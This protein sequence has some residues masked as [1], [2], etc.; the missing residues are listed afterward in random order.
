[1]VIGCNIL[2]AI[3]VSTVNAASQSFLGLVCWSVRCGNERFCNGSTAVDFWVLE[4]ACL[5][6]RHWFDVL[7]AWLFIQTAC[8]VDLSATSREVSLNRPISLNHTSKVQPGVYWD[9]E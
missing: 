5:N 4:C 2:V 8:E 7:L 9:S 3:F 1:M 6:L